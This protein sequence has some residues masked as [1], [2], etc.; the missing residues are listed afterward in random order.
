MPTEQTDSLDDPPTGPGAGMGPPL[1]A[2]G[3]ATDLYELRMAASY[4]KRGMTAPATFSLFVRRLPRNRRFLVAAGLDDALR[5][6]ERFRFDD[7]QLAWLSGLGFD[8][9]ARAALADLTFDGDVWAV[10]EGTIVFPDEPLVEVTAPL[11]VAQLIETLVLNQITYQ[12]AIA[13][14]AAR[15]RL[16]ADGR[17]RLVDFAFRRTHG[18]EAGLAAARASAIA[19]FDGTS[20]TEAARRFGLEPV[21]TMA[22]SYVEAF[23]SEQAAFAA[24]LED[25]PDHATLLVDTYDTGVGVERAIAAAGAAM[26]AADRAVR[27]GVRLDSGDLGQLAVEAR[28]R[29]DSA[30]HPQATIVASSSLDEH[31]IV[32][33][34][35]AGA[36]IDVFGVGTRMGV[37][38]DAPSLDSVYKLVDHDGRPIMKLSPGKETRPG[39]K[40]VHRF[41]DRG[42]DRLARRSESPPPGATALLEPVMVAGRRVG[43]SAGSPAEIVAAARARFGAQLEA[44]SDG[45][46]SIDPGPPYRVEISDA[47]VELTRSTRRRLTEPEAGP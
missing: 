37:S 31:E 27:F 5:A 7:D 10:P 35:A 8:R 18:L 40:Q 22:H 20:N 6:I 41:A 9:E 36:P 38:A 30:G 44:L 2:L 34:V 24:F 21:G 12:T 15:C 1:D 11:P 14:K 28:A 47:L 32:R 43:A 45:V 39:P 16:A 46:A 4:W 19:G 13:S 25:F 42:H 23:P 33:L 17:A 26:A 29:L 3:L